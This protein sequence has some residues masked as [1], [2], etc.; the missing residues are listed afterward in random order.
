MTNE[1]ACVYFIYELFFFSSFFILAN[2][3]SVSVASQ[4]QMQLVRS[5]TE[6]G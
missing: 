5:E 2:E 3:M 1:N 4:V 6:S